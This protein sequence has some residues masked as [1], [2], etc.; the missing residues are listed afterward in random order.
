MDPN[1]TPT[2]V[3]LETNV[4]NIVIQLNAKKAPESVSNFLAYVAAD[5]YDGLIFH[6]VINGFMIQ[7]GGFDSDMAKRPTHPPIR[8][9]SDN[10]LSNRIGTIAMARTSDP[11]S[12]TAQFF[13][14]VNNNSNLDYAPGRWGYAV[15]GEIVEGMNVVNQI[16]QASTTRH[17]GYSDVPARPIIILDAVALP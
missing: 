10:N 13:I 9:E 6:R 15:F 14:N 7:G 1:A 2:K 16:K 11:H 8:N 12:A 4:G 5:Y 17:N 3:R